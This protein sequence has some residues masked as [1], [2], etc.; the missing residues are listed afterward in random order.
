MAAVVHTKARLFVSGRVHLFEKLKTAMGENK[1]PLVWIHCASLGE[2]EQGRPIIE[3]L[4]KQ[5]PSL[6]ILLTF[7]SPSGYE[8]RKNY[9]QADYIFYLP[10]D[11]T[12]NARQFI[13]I[14]K[15]ALVIFI[16]YEFWYNYI[17]ELKKNNI[18]IIS[19]SSIFRPDQ[20]FF[21]WYGSFFRGILKKITYFFVQTP[22]SVALLNQLGINQTILAGDTRFDRV[23]EITQQTTE[24]EIARRFKGN[25][26]TFVIGSLWPE[27]LE[28]LAPFINEHKNSINFILAPHEIDERFL[29]Q[30]ETAIHVKSIRYSQASKNPESCSVL[31]IDNIGML[32]KL[33]RYGEFAYIGGAFGKGLHNILEA[34]CYGIP[35]FFGNKNY[36]KFQEANDLIMRGGAFAVGDYPELKNHFELMINKPETFLLACDVTR[37]YVKE[38]LGATEKIVT[39]CNKLLSA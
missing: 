25:E 14:T 35:I 20:I 31:I 1:N 21:K 8:V 23:F 17:N 5:D 10:W 22:Q 13:A 38:N 39:Y 36:Q 16:K 9:S 24:I 33:Y 7:F 6:K 2:F 34:A 4:K 37:A 28:L 18:P 29:T 19:A 3:A 27:D 11:L 15:P 26:K 12:G 30:I 32:S